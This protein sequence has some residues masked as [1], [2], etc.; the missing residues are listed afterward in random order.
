MFPY[1][2]SRASKKPFALDP[3]YGMCRYVSYRKPADQEHTKPEVH[4]P[5]GQ[6]AF[7][8]QSLL[9]Y[10]WGAQYLYSI[11]SRMRRCEGPKSYSHELSIQLLMLITPLEYPTR[12]TAKEYAEGIPPPGIPPGIRQ[13]G[14]RGGYST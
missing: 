8:D 14:I 6:S 9:T 4:K 2:Q 13:V 3:S 12:N 10:E 7:P 11:V 5:E 1:A